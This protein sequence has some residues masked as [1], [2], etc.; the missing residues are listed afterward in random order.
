M[1]ALIGSKF[2]LIFVLAFVV[3]CKSD[4]NKCGLS[5][6]SSGLI[7]G[8]VDSPRGK[9]PWLVA[10]FYIEENKFFCGATLISDRHI[11][12][13]EKTFIEFKLKVL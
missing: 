8:G 9:W 13:G 5:D 11:L 2:I 6:S 10:L 12:T 1:I 7:I 3:A 4:A